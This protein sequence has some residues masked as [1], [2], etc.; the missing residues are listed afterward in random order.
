M[1]QATAGQAVTAV[2]AG[3]PSG[4]VGTIGVRIVQQA[5]GTTVVGRTTAGITE[6]VSGSGIYTAQLT[7]PNTIAN[8]IIVWD[9]GTVTPQTVSTEELQV[10]QSLPTVGI[11]GGGSPVNELI[12]AILGEGAFDA[13]EQ[14]A[15]RWLDRRH[16]L[17]CSRSKCLRKTI[18]LGATVAGQV[19]YPLPK[20]V[21][22]IRELTVA[23]P[24]S[25]GY[26]AGVGVPY[27]VGRTSDLAQGA[28]SYIWLGGIYLAAG[29][30]IFTRDMSAAGEDLVALFPTPT[31]GGLAITL[32]TVCRPATLVLGGNVATPPEYDD[33]LVAG[34]IATGLARLEARPDLAVPNESL[35]AAACTELTREVN[36]RYRGAGPARIRVM[37]F[38]A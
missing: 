21:Q 11:V 9:T 3:A 27:G 6:P 15:L 20:E 35:F 16:K 10:L 31:E 17:M 33:A 2:A 5:T 13:S 23:A 4:L 29:G 37:G 30:G 18:S 26:P 7:A 24:P 34:A 1:I 36:A 8:Y 14:Q 32:K 28:L 22:E 19:A 12:E 38:N 25:L